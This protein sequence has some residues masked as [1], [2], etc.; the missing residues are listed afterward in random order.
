M[1][2]T[3]STNT[4]KKKKQKTPKNPVSD[5]SELIHRVCVSM[6]V[7]QLFYSLLYKSCMILSLER[8]KL[9]SF[10]PGKF[11]YLNI[12]VLFAIRGRIRNT[13][14]IIS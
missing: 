8:E 6:C 3:M 13:M 1:T 10:I 14:I 12:L 11:P 7:R 9:V 4:V 2:V 5:F